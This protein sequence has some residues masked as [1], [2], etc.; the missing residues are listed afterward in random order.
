M[1]SGLNQVE[2]CAK[3]TSKLASI[4]IVVEAIENAMNDGIIELLHGTQASNY[5]E[6]LLDELEH[7]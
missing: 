3:C 2:R 5:S 7:L 6:V 1:F 4:D